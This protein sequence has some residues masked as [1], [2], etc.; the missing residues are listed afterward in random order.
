MSSHIRDVFHVLKTAVEKASR[1]D[2]HMNEPYK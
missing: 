1:L 2:G